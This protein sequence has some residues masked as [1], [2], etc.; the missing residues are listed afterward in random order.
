[1]VI[2]A[3]AFDHADPSIFTVL[4]TPTTEPGTALCDF[5]ENYDGKC[6]LPATQLS[7]P[8]PRV[9]DGLRGKQL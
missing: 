2:N 4:T 8:P 1:M 9:D 5:G 3:V 7:T 6:L